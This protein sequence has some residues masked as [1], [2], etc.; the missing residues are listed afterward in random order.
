MVN[1]PSVDLK[2]IILLV[3]SPSAGYFL[4][5]AV[6]V[7][8]TPGLPTYVGTRPVVASR[9]PLTTCAPRGPVYNRVCDGYFLG[10]D[11]TKKLSCCVLFC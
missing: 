3:L 2:S 9:C 5:Q 1:P 11:G 6:A 10:V 8:V 7:F 4:R